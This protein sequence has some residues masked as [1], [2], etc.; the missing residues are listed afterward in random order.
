MYSLLAFSPD[1]R[2]LTKLGLADKYDS[3]GVIEANGTLKLTEVLDEVNTPFP[4]PSSM[5]LSAAPPL[6]RGARRRDPQK[7][8]FGGPVAEYMGSSEDKRF[9]KQL[10]SYLAD[11]IGSEDIY[12]CA[13]AAIRE[14]LVKPT[15]K[16]KHWKTRN[17]NNRPKRLTYAERKQN[18]ATK[19]EK[20]KAVT[21]VQQTM[22][23]STRRRSVI[24]FFYATFL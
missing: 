7:Y 12:L 14:D 24:S 15:D 9:K 23:T 5:L 17:A 8:I 6:L 21:Q 18:I 11:H 19:I 3:E 10:T 4:R 13:H 20:F 16:S 22:T 2:A 1:C